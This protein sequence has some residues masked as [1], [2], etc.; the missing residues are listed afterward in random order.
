MP[1]VLESDIRLKG[2][3]LKKDYRDT[4]RS[5]ETFT[6]PGFKVWEVMM[7]V[8]TN[9]DRQWEADLSIDVDGT[10]YPISSLPNYGANPYLLGHFVNLLAGYEGNAYTSQWLNAGDEIS[11][12]NTNFV[13]SDVVK[14]LLVYRE[15]SV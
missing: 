15:Y 11:V 8:Y 2:S 6:V 13:A 5:G 12:S 1:D 14:C 7:L 3:T 4:S 9:E 10:T